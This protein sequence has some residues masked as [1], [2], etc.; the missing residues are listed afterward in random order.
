MAKKNIEIE[1]QVQVENI[2]PLVRF[3]N[4]NA[5]KI[6]K[7]RQIDEYFIPKH[8]NFLAKKPVSEWLRLRNANGNYSINYKNWYHGEDGKSHHRDEY[9]TKIEDIKQ[10]H[11]IFKS[12]NIKPI[13]K[14]D[15]TRTSYLY[16][17]YEVSID[18]VESL[19]DFVEIEYKGKSDGKNAKEVADEMG[20]FLKSFKVGKIYRNY[21]GYPFQLLFPKGFKLEEI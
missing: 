10:L 8:R 16:K 9:E 7:T 6:I 19:G 3:L 17:K 4:T 18:R 20:Q 14:V 21:V 15:K 2:K 5:K 11:L 1:I 12:L 13:V